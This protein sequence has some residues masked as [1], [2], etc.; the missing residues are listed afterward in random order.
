MTRV[1]VH[2]RPMRDSYDVVVVGGG[3][4]GLNGALMLARSK[5]SVV[6]IDAGAPRNAPADGIHGLLGHDGLPPAELLRR[7]RAEVRGYGGEVVEGEVESAVPH[8]NGFT[9]TLTDG[10]TVGARR[11]LVTTGLVDELPDIPGLRERWGRDVVHCPYCHGWEVRDRPIGVISSGPMSVHQAL[12]F[13]QLS[14]DVTFFTHTRPAP[15]GDDAAKLANRGIS[16]VD[17][18]VA[19][20]DADGLRLAD[21]TVHPVGAV[22]VATRMVARAGFLEKLGL[23]PVEHPAGVGE[24]VPSEP[25]GRT[26]VPGVWVAGNVTDLTAQVGTSAAAGA[27]AGAA[28]N[29]DLVNEEALALP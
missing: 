22:A 25:G 7:G 17:G 12:L 14:D 24:H 11:L 4:A 19:A 27:L 2:G 26:D 21:G 23:R 16:T 10:R 29:A 3:A 6:V 20:L 5:R 13:R 15:E 18:A 8:G 28:I 9:V 1:R